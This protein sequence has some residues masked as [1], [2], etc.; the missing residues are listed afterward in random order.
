MYCKTVQ[1]DCISKFEIIANTRFT[2]HWFRDR[3]KSTAAKYNIRC[4]MSI[5]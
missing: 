4:Y 1:S 3:N 2:M 5:S